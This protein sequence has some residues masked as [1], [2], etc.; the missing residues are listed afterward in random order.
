MGILQDN[1]FHQILVAVYMVVSKVYVLDILQ[2]LNKKI[3]LG[4]QS[5][6][7]SITERQ[8]LRFPSFLLQSQKMIEI[9][10]VVSK[11]IRSH[12]KAN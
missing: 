9:Q 11:I 12:L 8:F 6:V 2:R 5:I 7:A 3:G 4:N 1:T 10:F